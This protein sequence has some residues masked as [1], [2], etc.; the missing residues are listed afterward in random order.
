MLVKNSLLL[1]AATA[2]AVA[3]AS[4]EPYIVIPKGSRQGTTGHNN[5]GV[6]KPFNP[7][8]ESYGATHP[9]PLHLLPYKVGTVKFRRGLERRAQKPNELNRPN[10][11]NA[12]DAKPQNGPHK[13]NEH[14]PNYRPLTGPQKPNELNRPNKP[15]V[16]DSSK[17]PVASRP[18]SKKPLPMVPIKTQP[19]THKPLPMKPLSPSGGKKSK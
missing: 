1:L 15:N 19:N 4:P 8:V 10:K 9:P 6:A 2:M 18:D 12:A 16:P 3:T 14:P 5:Q 11:P 7:L 13:P 17:P